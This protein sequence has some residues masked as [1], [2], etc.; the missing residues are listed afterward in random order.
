MRIVVLHFQWLESYIK[1]L[2]MAGK[3]CVFSAQ[4]AGEGSLLS[5]TL[6]GIST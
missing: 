5:E 4:K 2:G 3:H 6:A 1:I